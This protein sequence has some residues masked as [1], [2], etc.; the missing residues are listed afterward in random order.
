MKKIAL[1]FVLIMFATSCENFLVED[2][3]QVI[4]LENSVLNNEAG[5]LAALAGAYKPM[6]HTW[7]S[8]FADPSILYVLFGGDDLTTVMHYGKVDIDFFDQ[9][10]VSKYSSYLLN[11][12]KGCYKSIQGCNHIIA[13]YQNASGEAAVINQVGGEAYF[14]RAHKV[15]LLWKCS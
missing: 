2:L 4:T 8:G 3:S 13:N 15:I 5:L 12:W 7:H 6:S 14:L 9:Y 10:Y 11:I 1:L